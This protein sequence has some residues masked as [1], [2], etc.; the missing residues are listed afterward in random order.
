MLFTIKTINNITKQINIIN[1][2][3]THINVYA[4]V[5]AHLP[6]ARPRHDRDVDASRWRHPD[7]V[8]DLDAATGGHRHP[9][10]RTGSGD[11]IAD[12]DELE[13]GVVLHD[14]VNLFFLFLAE[15]NNF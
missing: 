12:H 14:H 2:T 8:V 3:K 13:A 5:H 7:R 10:D 4:P 9:P 15:K 6:L 11:V 1:K